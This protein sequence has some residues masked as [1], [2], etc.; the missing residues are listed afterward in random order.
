MNNQNLLPL[1]YSALAEP[2]GVLIRV[3]DSTRAKALLYRTRAEAN[4]PELATLQ[5]RTSP[6]PD[7]DLVICRGGG[8][9][10]QGAEQKRLGRSPTVEDLEL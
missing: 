1:L 8:A 3:S 6:F 4:D 9:K 10:A 2:Y 7:G 5:I